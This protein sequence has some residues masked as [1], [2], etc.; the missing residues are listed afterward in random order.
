[1]NLS[2]LDLFLKRRSYFEE[3]FLKY[4]DFDLALHYKN[5]D[6]EHDKNNLITFTCGRQIIVPVGE[7]VSFSIHPR[8]ITIPEH[9]HNFIEMIY[10]YS[11]Q[12]RQTINNT[13]VLLQEG[14]ICI[15]DTN[16]IHSIEH[17]GTD[18][19]IVNCLMRKEYFDST[20]LSWLSGNDVLSSF[21][22][23]AIYQGKKHNDYILFHSGSNEKIRQLLAS[24]LCE[25]FEPNICTD[26]VINC[27]MIIIFSELLRI[28]KNDTNTRY[29]KS[30]DNINISDIILYLQNNLKNVTLESTADYFHF[31]PNYLSSSIKKITGRRFID[32]LQE[33]KLKRACYLLEI[34]NFSVVEI[35]NKIGYSNINFF[36]KIFKKYFGM[37]PSEYRNNK[38][39]INKT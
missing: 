36:Y 9:R 21:F 17:T 12:C 24:C 38:S 23:R 37:T 4:P 39:N 27:Y 31:N 28:Y 11:G 10:V 35:S 15:L 22:I 33:I 26:K 30:L 2:D 18:D 19:V 14:E 34:S 7:D 1:M 5:N 3:L 25:Y 16:V 6:D 8:F 20:L 13:E 29:Y 32:V